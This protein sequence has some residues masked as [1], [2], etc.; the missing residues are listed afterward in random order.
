MTS[1]RE[2]FLA[3]PRPGILR[4]AGG[5]C[6]MLDSL[7]GHDRW[8]VTWTQGDDP[9]DPKVMYNVAGRRGEYTP[10]VSP[11]FRRAA[12]TRKQLRLPS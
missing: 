11:G 1:T 2:S 10:Q 9:D 7:F 12:H 4:S 5:A 8:D 3:F 6:L